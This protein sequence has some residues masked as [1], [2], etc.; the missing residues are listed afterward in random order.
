MMIIAKNTEETL[1]KALRTCWEKAPTQRCVYLKLS[2]I[3]LDKEHWLPHI[4][5]ALE[6]FD[7]S[8]YAQLYICKDND[9]FIISRSMTFKRLEQFLAHLAPK[10]EPVPL[11]GLA[12]LFE[13]GVDWW[14]LRTLCEKKLEAA[15]ATSKI[16]E[17]HDEAQRPDT[18][19]GALFSQMDKDLISSLHMRRES[20]L[21]PEIMVVEDDPFS[22]KLVSNVLEKQYNV[23]MSKDGQGALYNYVNKAPDILFL[24]I[25][26]PDIDG[27]E[28]LERIFKID[29]HAYVVMFSGNGDKKNI[30][31]AIEAGA[32]GFVGKPFTQEKLLHYI[33]KSPF[34]KAKVRRERVHG[35]TIH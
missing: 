1:L 35:D 7:Q 17:Y 18:S 27:H 5:K 30:L 15:K 2:R 33:A 22:R 16:E 29:P 13:I 9:I 26:L 14:H 34:V 21:Y 3:E 8:E 19:V 24:D 20:R 28:V 32:K 12:S 23:N 6:N 25:G 4:T 11:Q 10:L 31:R